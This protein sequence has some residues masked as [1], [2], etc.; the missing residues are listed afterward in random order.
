M[1]SG[2]PA[3]ATSRRL[4]RILGSGLLVVVAVIAV[5]LGYQ[6]L[7]SQSSTAASPIDLLPHQHHGAPAA[8]VDGLPRERR[9]ALGVADGVVPD[10]T[11]VFDDH[12]PAVAELDPDL[13]RALRAA[14]TDAAR[15]GVKVY[16]SNGWRSRA[17]QEQLFQEAVSTYGST[18]QAARW[19][20][21]P[22]T[23][24]HE[25]GDAV[26][27]GHT[28]AATWLSEHGAA[29]GLCRVY[30]NEPWHYELRPG[31]IDHGCPHTYADPTHDPRM[32]H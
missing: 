20:A 27:V 10:G 2:T 21:V 31:A 24:A 22:G 30:G 13:S 16:V 17:Y 11:T 29:Y 7:A 18:K 23:S 32:R 26:D 1:T 5:A 3:R 19:V 15:D 14:T 25:S 12:V 4:P 6:S 28:D 9:G 8:P